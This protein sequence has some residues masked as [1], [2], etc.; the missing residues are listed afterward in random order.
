[1]T[2]PR[3][4]RE[5]RASAGKGK[6]ANEAPKD[7]P[8]ESG[9]PKPKTTTRP[10]KAADAPGALPAAPAGAG[11]EK[12]AGDG[13]SGEKKDPG[14]GASRRAP[15]R[16]KRSLVPDGTTPIAEFFKQRRAA[17]APTTAEI[18]AAAEEAKL[19]VLEGGK[20]SLLSGDELR[21][22]VVA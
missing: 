11:G 10:P 7:P 14:P 1:M 9:P 12:A 20:P 19:I 16:K 6:K 4:G 2:Q 3:S 15:G 8:A 21:E 22:E 5:A 17:F 13:T 18:E